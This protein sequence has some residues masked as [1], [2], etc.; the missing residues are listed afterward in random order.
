MF[1]FYNYLVSEST[2]AITVIWQLTNVVSMY[3]K[4]ESLLDPDKLYMFPANSVG[5][6]G[7]KAGTTSDSNLTLLDLTDI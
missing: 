4:P 6:S 5:V 7:T 2:H 3:N 1:W